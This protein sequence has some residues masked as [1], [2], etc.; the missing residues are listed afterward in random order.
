VISVTNYEFDN[1]VV[2]VTRCSE[3]FYTVCFDPENCNLTAG[4]RFYADL[5]QVCDQATLE[6]HK[7]VVFD[8]THIDF[9]ILVIL[10]NPKIRTAEYSFS[11]SLKSIIDIITDSRIHKG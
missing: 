5:E 6:S 7:A 11:D 8:F 4:S 9:G 3:T 2:T 10:Y 1:H